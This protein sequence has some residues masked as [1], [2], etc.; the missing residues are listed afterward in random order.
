MKGFIRFFAERHML[1]Y[2]ITI[3]IIIIGL[4]TLLDIKRD[5]YPAV[6]FGIV[7]IN[8]QY[9]GASPEDVE[10]NVTN[11]IEKEIQ[12]VTGIDRFTSTSMENISI[13]NVFI[14]IDAKDQDKIKNNIREAVGRVT[15]YPPEVTDAPFVTE[16]THQSGNS[17]IEVGL[18]GELPYR[19]MREQARLFEKKLKK[20]NGVSHLERVG[21][22]ARE[23]KIEVDPDAIKDYQIP[24][25][26]IITAIQSRNIRGTSG[27]FESYTSEKDLVTLA[28]FQNPLEVGDVIVRS[29]FDGPLIKVKDLAIV[30]DDFEDQRLLTRVNGLSA[31]TFRVFMKENADVIRTC[32]AIKDLVSAEQDQMLEGIDPIYSNDTSRYIRTSFDVV[33]KNGVIGL[34]LVIILLPVFLNF[35]TA[36]WVAMGIPVAF[37]GAVFLIPQFGGYLDT[38]TLSGMILVIGIIVDDAIIIAENISKRRE[39]GDDPVD[40]AVNGTHEVIRPVV[41]TVLTTFLVFA[42]MFFMPGI[43]GKYIIPIP[44]AISLALFV[45]LIESVI[46]L[47]AHLVTGMKKR[48]VA[49]TGRTWFK[50]IV[51]R[52]QRVVRRFLRFRYILLPV[53]IILLVGSLWYAGNYMKMIMFPSG[54]AREF[55]AV[56]ELPVGTPLHVTSKKMM[57]LESLVAELPEDELDSYNTWIGINIMVNAESENYAALSVLLTPFTERERS[58]E[59]IVESLRVKAQ[60]IEGIVDISF[61]IA[62]GGPPVGK[63]ISLQIV[64]S[65]DALRTALADSV[66]ALLAAM[67]GV[68]DI[69]RNDVGGKD[70]IAINIDYDH[71]SRVGLTVADVARNVRLAFDGEVVTNVRY[72]DEDVAFR[73]IIDEKVRQ[74]LDFVNQILIP[75]R[76]GRMIP[77]GDLAVLVP[78]P[79]QPDIRHFD[80]ERT[81]TI[82]ADVDQDSITP[83]EATNTVLNHYNISRDWPGIQ[84]SLGG[85]VFETQESMTGLFRTMVFAV[86]GVFF[87]LILLF[88]SLT[89]PFLVM[90][91]IPFGITGVII[92][93]G[94]HGEPFSFIGIM[95]I[96][97]LSG[98]V[99]NDSLVLVNH[100]NELRRSRPDES[101]MDIVAEGT[102][103]RLR[104]IVMTTITTVAALLPLAYGIGGTALFM[105]PMALALSWGLIFATPLTLVLVP[106]LYMIGQDIRIRLTRGGKKG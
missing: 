16:L 22:Q 53:F 60:E 48:T 32:D 68:K 87:L 96:I 19:E 95:G 29:T 5:V 36:F 43:F 46:A 6:D 49:S 13:I 7:S 99:V 56:I 20:I 79:G 10:L 2:I 28:Q 72:G 41:T 18:T 62:T 37:L 106:C 38:I 94:F 81:V 31:I 67:N 69:S 104:A 51:T 85:E 71:L 97:G 50:S 8:T 15:D 101:V 14:D 76:Q 39:L 92:A 3:M 100:I 65:D 26:E 86:L 98:V 66:T 80:S 11:K 35:R 27:S 73:V 78:G 105:A 1:A 75:N 47:P 42:P 58:A 77:L 63:P 91:A 70:Q 25:R 57:E 83:L 52:Y 61:S 90:M 40:A 59:E 64:G 103:D 93:F 33:L 54:M 82:E 24:M 21:Y 44:L 74:D 9:P 34:I 84:L 17:I 89:Q 12:T 88:N 45:S 30:R 4:G 102:A 23:I 55:F